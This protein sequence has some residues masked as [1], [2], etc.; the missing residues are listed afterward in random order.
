MSDEAVINYSSDILVKVRHNQEVSVTLS[1]QGTQG[2]QGEKGE[3]GSVT[4]E[5][6]AARNEAVAAAANAKIS[7]TNSKTSETAAKAAQSGAA[8]SATF[9]DDAKKAAETAKLD[10][11]T[12]AGAA[13][14]SETAAGS[15][16]TDAEAAQVV[17]EAA[18]KAAATSEA[19]ALA[20]K[21]AAGAS[22]TAAAGSAENADASASSASQS[23]TDADASAKAA[24]SSAVSALASKTAASASEAN[25]LAYRNAASTHAAAAGEVK[26]AVDEANTEAQNARTAAEAAKDAAEVARTQAQ[27]AK[28]GSEA[29]KTLAESARDAAQTAR[30]GAEAAIVDAEA[31]RDAAEEFAGAAALSAAEAA[32]FD[33]SSYPMKINNGSDFEDPAQVRI[34]IGAAKALDTVSETEATAGTSIEERNWNALRVRQAIA[35]YA[36]AKAHLHSVADI[37]GLQA[38]LNALAPMVS[39]VFTGT[40]MAPTAAAK[41]NSAR[42]ATTEYVDGAISDLIGG[43]VPE[44]LDT[45]KEIADKLTEEGD[46][47]IALTQ[48]VAGKSDVGHKHIMA[49]ITDLADT[50]GLLAPKASPAFTGNPTATTQAANDD[51]TRLATTAHVKAAIAASGL[52]TE[53][54]KHEIA[55]V[56]GLQSILANKSNVDHKHLAADITDLQGLLDAKAALISPAFEGNPTAPTQPVGNSSTR[57]A[58]TAFVDTA[59]T[60]G[61]AGKANVGHEHV[62]ADTT[63]LQDALDAKAPLQSPTLSGSP[64]APTATAG[65]NTTQIATTAFVGAAVSK[66]SEDLTIAGVDG[67][68]TA[69]DAKWETA[70]LTLVSQAEAESGSMST[71]RVW[72]AQRVRQAIDKAAFQTNGT[73][74]AGTDVDTLTTPGLWHQPANANA[75]LALNYPVALAGMLTVTASGSMVYQ[76]YVVYN[77]GKVYSRVKYQTTW[78]SWVEL[79]VVGHAHAIADVT[80]LGSALDDRLAKAGGLMTGPINFNGFGSGNSITV[81]NGD[82]ATATATNLRLSSWYGIG[83]MNATSGQSVPQWENSHWFNVRNGDMG[84]RGSLTASGNISAY[85]DKRLKSDI[86][87]VSDA[88]GMVA[89]MRGVRFTMNGQRNVGVIAQEMRKV[90]PEVVHQ[91]DDKKKTLSVSY[92]NIIGVLIEA[93]K[94]LKT[95]IDVLKRAG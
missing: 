32:K 31:A 36:P 8:I 59:V 13:S 22:A 94:E 44:T 5:L 64:K 42:I 62:I 27:T 26:A 55:D 56:N 72:S 78:S 89:K 79:S 21:N 70:D 29:A 3:T 61:V 52:S 86:V 35:A 45:L 53:G 83:F 17:A 77:S 37:N 58:T 30:T 14:A 43:A 12:A 7:E 65:T 19:N 15:A 34:N 10:A 95:E 63:G 50:L 80:G 48:Q 47:V 68:Q 82:A 54:H 11:E 60:N 4:P 38:A 85:S 9:A 71:A 76:S 51:S 18:K 57:L 74:A 93:I 16:K 1:E 25:A 46:A 84:M 87:T 81:G 73:I 49:D 90:L 66:F 2:P 24:D 92:G 33:P 23:A 6:A 41:D 91:A 88:L 28:T 67:L 39:P 20:S 75:T 69:L 40:P